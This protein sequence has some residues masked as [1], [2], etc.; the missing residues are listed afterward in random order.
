MDWEPLTID[1]ALVRRLVADQFPDWKDLSIQPV[2]I[3][4]WDNRTFHLGEQMLVRPSAAEYAPRVAKEQ[5]WLPK[6]APL[7]PLQIPKSL[8]MGEP[9]EEYPWNWSIYR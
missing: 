3:G 9:N 2:A 5:K 4:G 1:S 6:L 8:A 7:L